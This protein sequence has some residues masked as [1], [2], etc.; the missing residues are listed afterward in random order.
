MQIEV[1]RQ[2]VQRNLYRLLG[3]AKAAI[4]PYGEVGRDTRNVLEEYGGQL[5]QRAW[6]H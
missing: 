4:Y 3:G 6:C 2:R 5:R 1:I